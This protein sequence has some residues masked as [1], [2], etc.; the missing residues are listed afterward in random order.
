MATV[1]K[2]SVALV[3]LSRLCGRPAVGVAAFGLAHLTD[4]T[5]VLLQ[6]RG[7]SVG[8]CNT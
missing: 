5:A 6:N 8:L 1:P 3:K 2:E 7:K 4:L